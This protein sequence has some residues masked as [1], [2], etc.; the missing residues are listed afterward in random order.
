MDFHRGYRKILE[1]RKNKMVYLISQ[2][3]GHSLV[4]DLCMLNSF[5]LNTLYSH[6]EECVAYREQS[7][8]LRTPSVTYDVTP[9]K[10]PA[11]AR[12]DKLVH[13]NEHQSSGNEHVSI[14]TVMDEY[15][16]AVIPEYSPV[17]LQ[18]VLFG[19]WERR[20]CEG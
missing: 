5:T 7:S 6:G 18:P 8:R 13:V 16:L 11:P 17:K 2:I 10:R 1:I 15:L 4:F 14:E 9:S 12:H 20:K 19:E 3:I